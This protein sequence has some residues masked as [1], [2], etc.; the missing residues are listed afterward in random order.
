MFVNDVNLT[1]RPPV[2]QTPSTTSSPLST[3]VDLYFF[4][5]LYVSGLRHIVTAL[6]AMYEMVCV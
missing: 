3:T 4:L 6:K 5:Y 1:E 2:A